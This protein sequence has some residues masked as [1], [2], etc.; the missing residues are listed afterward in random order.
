VRISDVVSLSETGVSVV[1]L[2]VVF[3]AESGFGHVLAAY[4]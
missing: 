4:S 3:S 1:I 2:C